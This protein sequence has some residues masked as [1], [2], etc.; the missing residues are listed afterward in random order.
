[1][2]GPGRKGRNIKPGRYRDVSGDGL[3]VNGDAFCSCRKESI[4]G[5]KKGDL[6]E[7]D[8]ATAD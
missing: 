5:G 8:K 3:L 7:D 6:K 2:A 4:T 1:M